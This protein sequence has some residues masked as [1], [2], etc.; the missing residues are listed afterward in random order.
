MPGLALPP[1]P[2][3]AEP[4]RELAGELVGLGEA[5]A[6]ARNTTKA[7]SAGMPKELLKEI[8]KN[9]RWNPALK[10]TIAKTAPPEFCKAMESAGI[11]GQY[12]NLTVLALS[13]A[14]LAVGIVRNGNETE[15]LI[16]EF[17]AAGGKPAEA[18]K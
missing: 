12:Q 4:L 7:V 6:V 10:V 14:C 15:R 9:S 17:K 16:A 5:A 8:E 11:S 2:W 3:D 13:V 1:V 18:K